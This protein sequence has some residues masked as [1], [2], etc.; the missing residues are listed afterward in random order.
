MYTMSD[1][2]KIIISSLKHKIMLKIFELNGENNYYWN[3]E[4]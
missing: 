1:Q 2:C 4:Y 3:S